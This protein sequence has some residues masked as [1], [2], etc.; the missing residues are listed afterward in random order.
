[1]NLRK[2]IGKGGGGNFLRQIS[3]EANFSRVL[4]PSL[5][6]KWLHEFK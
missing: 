6:V 1:M 5:R 4:F 3:L 2:S